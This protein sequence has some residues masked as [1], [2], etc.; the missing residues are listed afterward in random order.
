VLDDYRCDGCKLV[1]KE[2]PP[3]KD[4]EG[5]SADDGAAPTVQV[6]KQL[7]VGE[8]PRVLILTLKRYTTGRYGKI[9]RPIAFDET[10]DLSPFVVATP[11]LERPSGAAEVVAEAA[12]EGE[13]E[14]EGEGEG[15]GEGEEG[16]K[17]PLS[18]SASA[19]SAAAADDDDDD[20]ASGEPSAPA[21]HYS[22]VGVVVHQDMRG[23][24]FFGHYIAFVRRGAHWYCMDDETTRRVP[25][26]RVAAQ[27][28]YMLFYQATSAPPKPKPKPAPPPSPAEPEDCGDVGDLA[29]ATSPAGAAPLDRSASAASALGD[30]AGAGDAAAAHGPEP[31]AAGL[32]PQALAP[33]NHHAFRDGKSFVLEIDLP[34]CT[35]AKELEL[36]PYD[37]GG[38]LRLSGKYEFAYKWPPEVDGNTKKMKLK[39]VTKQRKLTVTAP[40]AKF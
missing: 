38:V 11:R 4:G 22:L 39:F 27:N 8:P 1:S 6:R 16:A 34:E 21:A 32:P 9:S 18:R 30:D 26:D 19:V 17:P 28:A 37:E 33:P 12:A 14:A 3:A 2:A 24:C 13:A 31:P 23:S 36:H 29:G 40:L 7:L 35:S 5:T 20:D 10:L 25:W 15:E